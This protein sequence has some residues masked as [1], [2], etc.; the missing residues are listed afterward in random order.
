MSKHC[1]GWRG[2]A[3]MDRH[4]LGANT[5]CVELYR[6]VECL[7]D[8]WLTGRPSKRKQ[9]TSIAVV[10]QGMPI[11]E[12]EAL[13]HSSKSE[14]RVHVGCM[15]GCV[16]AL[17]EYTMKFVT[18]RVEQTT[19]TIATTYRGYLIALRSL[20]RVCPTRCPYSDPPCS[21]RDLPFSSLAHHPQVAQAE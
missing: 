3:S 16:W 21:D 18:S 5:Q 14:A 9:L 17:N 11:A 7:Q 15:Q 6:G 20:Q 2:G 8:W 19:E 10:V 4:S 12:E 1:D 13:H